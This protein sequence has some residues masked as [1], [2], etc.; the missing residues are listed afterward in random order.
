MAQ[1][2]KQDFTVRRCSTCGV[3]GAAPK[4]S[5]YRC[6]YTTIHRQIAEAKEKA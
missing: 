3:S 5:R 6:P 1:R 2:S 4:G